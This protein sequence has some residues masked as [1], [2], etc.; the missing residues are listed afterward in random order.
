MLIITCFAVLIAEYLTITVDMN[1]ED[2]NGDTALHFAVYAGSPD[3]VAQGADVLGR[4][5]KCSTALMKAPELYSGEEEADANCR[6]CMELL[7]EHLYKKR[8]KSWNKWFG[9]ITTTFSMQISSGFRYSG[10]AH[11]LARRMSTSDASPMVLAHTSPSASPCQASSSAGRSYSAFLP[12]DWY[13]PSGTL[14]A[15][16]PQASP[17]SC[18]TA[19]ASP[20]PHATRRQQSR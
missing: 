1:S 12:S 14:M 18:R 3:V 17:T 5:Y 11:S 19:A 4:G 2:V 6:A 10:T 7:L 9:N 13:L 16:P 8:K 20:R 15:A